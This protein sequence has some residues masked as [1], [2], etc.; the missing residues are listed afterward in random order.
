VN[1]ALG[2][3]LHVSCNRADKHTV[4]LFFHF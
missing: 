2:L 3:Q 1:T 4:S